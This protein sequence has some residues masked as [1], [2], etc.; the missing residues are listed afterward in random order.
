MQEKLQKCASKCTTKDSDMCQ[1]K[2]E[3]NINKHMF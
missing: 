3:Y 1:Y 2:K